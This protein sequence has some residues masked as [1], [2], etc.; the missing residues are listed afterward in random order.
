LLATFAPSL[1][2]IPLWKG[3][4]TTIGLPF[5]VAVMTVPFLLTG[6]YV[7]QANRAFDIRTEEILA[8]AREA[9]SEKS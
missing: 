2:G 5:G 7:Y 4:A 6:I 3:A 1:F 9:T 8:E